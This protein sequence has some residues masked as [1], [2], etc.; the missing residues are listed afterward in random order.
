MAVLAQDKRLFR[1]VY[2]ISFHILRFGVHLAFHI[3]DPLKL[4]VPEHALIVDQ[5]GRI[6]VLKKPGHG[7]DVLP[8]VRLVPA[9]PYKDSRM[10]LVPLHHGSGPVHHTFLPLGQTSRHVPGR[11]A[12]PH[13]LPGTVAL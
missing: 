13:L 7:K 1:V 5:P 8:C 11:L 9:G 2:E 3:A 10:V 6:P 4:P 12:G